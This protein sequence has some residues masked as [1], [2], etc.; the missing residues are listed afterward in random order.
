[1]KSHVLH[2]VKWHEVLRASA[3]DALKPRFF[4]TLSPAGTL[5]SDFKIVE[6]VSCSNACHV[7]RTRMRW[8]LCELINFKNSLS[9]S[10]TLCVGL[11]SIRLV[12]TS[13]Q[14]TCEATYV[15]QK[16]RRLEFSCSKV[17]SFDQLESW[18]RKNSVRLK[19]V[20]NTRHARMRRR[21]TARAPQRNS[22][23]SG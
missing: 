15:K 7:F 2:I 20:K 8:I 17:Q 10:R 6:P 14:R 13:R 21:M 22:Q 23:D 3:N 1:M 12:Q 18:F 19:H 16:R 4:G 9:N 11:D 5:G